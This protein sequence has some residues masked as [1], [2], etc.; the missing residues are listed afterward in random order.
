[1]AEGQ[2][3]IWFYSS[4]QQDRI[5][6]APVLEGF[7]KREWEVILMSD[8]V[9][10]WVAMRVQDYKETP[11]K[12]VMSGDLDD[13]SEESEETKAAKESSTPMVTWLGELLGEDVA[14]VRISSRL[15]ESP[16]VLV[17]KEGG[18]GSN[19]TRIL[20]AT[21]QEM[22]ASE[23]VL[24]INPEHPIVVNLV[25]LHAQQSEGIE[26][27][28]RLLLD[29]A[30]ISEGRLEDPQGFAGRLQILMERAAAGMANTPAQ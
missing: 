13:I 2:E 15:T 3:A 26:P 25:K 9:D 8:P 6:E 23:R 22:A 11:I 10:E 19:I 24:E 28:G 12:S 30:T 17:D 4:L 16:S 14:E 20:K 29:H 18:L 5:A 1:M 7:K 27:F 21:N